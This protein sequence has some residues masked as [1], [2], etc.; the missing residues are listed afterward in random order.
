MYIIPANTKRGNLI[1]SIFRPIDLI[2]FGTGLGVTIIALLIFQNLLNSTAITIACLAP[3]AI[4]ALLVA[5]VPYY[6]NVMNVVVEAY[7][8]FTTTQKM[9]WKGWCYLDGDKK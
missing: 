2:V 7:E 1:F 8:F 4:C 5:P 3:A 6:H 9:I